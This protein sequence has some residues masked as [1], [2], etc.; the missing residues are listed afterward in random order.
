[1]LNQARANADAGGTQ[2]PPLV[3]QAFKPPPLNKDNSP[4][5]R[6]AWQVYHESLVSRTEAARNEA[7]RARPSSSGTQDAADTPVPRSSAA[8][9]ETENQTGGGTQ[10]R[11]SGSNKIPSAPRY[12]PLP[13]AAD[14]PMEHVLTTRELH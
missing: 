4:E 12:E 14:T 8:S 6:R 7:A 9:A 13:P 3:K 11:T 5:N 10:S 1:M 2:V